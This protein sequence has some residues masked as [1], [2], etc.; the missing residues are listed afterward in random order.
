MNTNQEPTMSAVPRIRCGG[1][2]QYPDEGHS[3]GCAIQAIAEREQQAARR[4]LSPLTSDEERELMVLRSWTS[5]TKSQEAR[6]WD[7][8]SR[9]ERHNSVPFS[10]VDDAYEQGHHDGFQAGYR[11]GV[12]DRGNPS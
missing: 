10:A 9:W 11:Q 7:L 6:Y 2:G 3:K 12:L 4:N 8:K 5:R 1:C